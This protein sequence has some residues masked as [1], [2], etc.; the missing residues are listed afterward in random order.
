MTFMS[1]G[2]NGYVETVGSLQRMYELRNELFLGV[3][4]SGHRVVIP[5]AL[6]D[7]LL[8]EL[9]KTHIGIV[10]AL[11]RSYFWWTKIDVDIEN[12]IKSCDTTKSQPVKSS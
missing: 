2:W 10:K 9:H 8:E 11:A 4:M 12:L 1:N 3:I 6:R 5:T 7:Q